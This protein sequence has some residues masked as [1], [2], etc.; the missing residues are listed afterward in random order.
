MAG[1]LDQLRSGVPLNWGQVEDDPALET[2]A[3]LELAGQECRAMP[4]QEP[5][6]QAKAALVERLSKNLAAPRL[7]PEKA[8]PK[9][10]AGFSEN[11]QVLTQ[12]EDNIN[13]GIN[14]PLA[15][16]R[17]AAGLALVILVV[18][19]IWTL[20]KS[21]T[22]P[23]FSWIEVRRS[24]EPVSLVTHHVA[25]DDLPCV[26]ARAD[27]PDRPGFFIPLQALRDAQANVDYNIPLFPNNITV[28]TTFT[29][30]LSLASI[31]PCDG[32]TLKGSDPAALIA[33]QYEARRLTFDPNATPTPNGLGRPPGI[34][35]TVA[36]IAL[37]ASHE[38]PAF[39]DAT[40]G[41]WKEVRIPGV[42]GVYWHGTPY[43]DLSGAEWNGDVN[44]LTI[45]H[46]D[47]VVTLVGSGIEGINEQVLV[48]IARNLAW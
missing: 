1:A 3:R 48:E 26:V 47:T 25:P 17:G 37:F 38:Q 7:K 16:L 44:V 36:T 29:F 10:L 12:V 27:N 13:L 46:E 28:P 6:P 4:L 18:W 14:W 22:T 24:G 35:A 21:A 39:V 15:I 43:H 19:G 30:Q 45:E 11:V 5:S 9:S 33:L 23:S 2:L 8:A 42:H 40:T 41:E 20:L 31:D 32:N 34:R